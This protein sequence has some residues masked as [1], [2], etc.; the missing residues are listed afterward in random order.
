[1]KKNILQITLGLIFL[2][3]ASC[4]TTP[5]GPPKKAGSKGFVSRGDLENFKGE[6]EVPG[7]YRE[8]T[9]FRTMTMMVRFDNVTLK[10]ATTTKTSRS[11]DIS[12][13]QVKS[14][15][16]YLENTMGQIKRFDI[17]MVQ[18]ASSAKARKEELEDIGELEYREKKTYGIDYMLTANMVLGGESYFQS[19]GNTLNTYNV[20]I[21]FAIVDDADS[22]VG[23]S[24]TV[25]GKSTRNYVRS[26][27]TGKYLAG[28][29]PEDQELAIKEAIFDAMT[30]AMKIFAKQFPVS[31]KITSI[32]EFD[33][34]RLV[35]EKG[36]KDGVPEDT[37]VCVWYDDSGAAIP[38]AYGNCKPEETG[39][40]IV[41]YK[42]NDKDKK[43]KSFIEQIQQPGWL[44]SSD[45]SALWATSLGLPYPLSI[46]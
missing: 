17:K 25:E 23:T 3:L 2:F 36:S 15:E 41:I 11:V 31:G 4:Q 42:W 18:S 14:A 30:K 33:F 45:K 37:Q 35:W 8:K 29:T 5:K 26:I 27:V 1:M 38:I 44:K 39:T 40:T 34:K 43:Y 10:Q 28:Y 19:D 22:V 16:I 7:N 9:S 13:N 12:A 24:F 20:T 6:M 21:A 32:S 46:N